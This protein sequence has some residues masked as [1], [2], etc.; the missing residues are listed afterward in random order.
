MHFE[1]GLQLAQAGDLQ[2]AERELRA[3]A[4]LKPGDAEYLSS[5]A[6]VL[7]IENKIE[8]STDLFEKALSIKPQDAGSRRDLSANLWQLHRFAEAK[9]HLKIVVKESPADPQAKLLLGLVSEKTGD[10]STAVTMLNSIPD[11]VR[12]QPEALIA[13][14]KSYYRLEDGK[15][16]A[17]TLSSFA[18]GPAGAQAALLGAQVADEMLDYATAEKLL[19]TIPKGTPEFQAAQYRLAVVK[20]DSRQYQQSRQILEDLMNSGQKTGPVL[21]LAGWCYHK[22]NRDEDAIRAFREAIQLD[23]TD[24]K[25]FLDLG[26]LLVEQR[27]LSAAL[28]L[29]NRM[30]SAFPRS[31]DALVLLGSIEFANERFKDAAQTYSRSLQ[32]DRDNRDAILGLAKSQA[33]AG[34]QDQAKNTLE[35]AIQRFPGKADFEMELALLL[36]KENEGQASPQQARAESL[37]RSAAKHDPNLAEAQYQLGDLELRRGRTTLAIAHLE[38]AVKI[39]PKSSKLHFSLARAYRR[40]GRNEDA[41]K[42]TA[43][44][45]KLKEARESEP[46]TSSHDE[47]PGE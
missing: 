4:K 1:R 10:Y 30:V 3:A 26:A 18:M 43:L 7:A 12:T 35:E 37:L 25:N 22:T 24:E 46:K 19:S 33:A 42:E 17:E 9:R 14:A 6:K 41:A 36:L 29:A 13:L 16:A 34:A 15:K 31:A 38:N 28:E 11:L 5:L 20:F 8:E 47:D 27:K 2:S 39:S 45:E 32:L 40:I 23:A 21:R 44:Y